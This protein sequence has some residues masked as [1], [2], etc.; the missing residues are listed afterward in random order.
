VTSHR[1]PG[2]H[3]AATSR[4]DQVGLRKPSPEIYDLTASKTGLP[5]GRCLSAD[6][7]EH[8]LPQHKTGH[9]HRAV[10]R[11]GRRGH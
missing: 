2:E 7:P 5:P 9:G 4:A 3:E 1:H 8:N 6:D 11:S 10:H